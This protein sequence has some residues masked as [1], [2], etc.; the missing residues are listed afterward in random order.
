MKKR[1]KNL[2]LP[3]RTFLR[4][5]RYTNRSGLVNQNFQ[6]ERRANLAEKN[7]PLPLHW[8]YDATANME[9]PVNIRP[10]AALILTPFT[11]WAQQPA[12]P[13]SAPATIRCFSIGDTITATGQASFP[14]GGT[15]F[16]LYQPR[17]KGLCIHYP[18]PSDHV[19]L[20]D[21]GTIGTKLP[22]DIYLEVT[23]ILT[24]QWPVV[25]PVGFKVLSFRNVDVEVKAEIAEWTR[26]CA[27]WQD[28]Q[29]AII[30]KQLHGGSTSRITDAQG[31][32]CGIV[33]VN[34]KL[35]HE[36]IGP[37]WRPQL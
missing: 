21:L 18:K 30:S 4:K 26:R 22:Q 8:V 29:L 24:D 25:Y 28:G 14:N 33:G 10:L 5:L 36:E 3:K 31:Q 11:A 37:I 20:A 2:P 34:A 6:A 16:V 17:A 27:Q 19:A 1:E 7:G 9:I 13:S 15:E 23:G 32:K 35:P 12:K